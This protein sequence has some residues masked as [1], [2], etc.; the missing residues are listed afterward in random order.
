MRRRLLAGVAA[1]LIASGAGA[2]RAIVPAAESPTMP[3]AGV[4]PTY[5]PAAVTAV[6]NAAAVTRRIW[7]PG[8]D[9]GYN[10]QGLTVAGGALYV[11]TYRSDSSSVHRG[12][13]RVFRLDPASGRETGH[14]DIPSPCGHAGGMAAG[15]DG[16]LYIADTHTLFATPLAHA[17][18]PGGPAFRSFPLGP[19]VVGALAVSTA[20]GI[21]LG[22]Y[23]PDRPGEFFRFTAATLAALK[24]GEKLTAALAATAMTIPDH[25][26]GAAI[27]PSGQLWVAR[28][29]TR[30]GTLDRLDLATGAPRARYDTAAGIEGIAFDDSGTLWAVSEAGVRHYYDQPFAGLVVPFY[31]LV[32]ALDL[33]RL[34]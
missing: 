24:D 3:I 19:G 4:A 18:D 5:G 32:F 15:G 26:Q 13:C 23:H 27:S 6:P 1:V 2:W 22:A 30:W 10:A 20:D 16:K 25:A 8:L 34:R 11:A 9:A 7:Q 28:S 14:F 31:P 29:N 33:A 17:F 12:P 21:W